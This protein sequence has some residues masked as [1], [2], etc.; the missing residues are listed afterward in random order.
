MRR[1]RHQRLSVLADIPLLDT[2]LLNTLCGSEA[3]GI[4]FQLFIMAGRARALSDP[5]SL[6]VACQ[7]WVLLLH[8]G[9]RRPP[10]S[11][12]SNGSTSGI[13]LSR[14]DWKSFLCARILTCLEAGSYHTALEGP[15][16]VPGSAL[17]PHTQ[18]RVL[19]APASGSDTEMWERLDK[20]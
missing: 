7:G 10:L 9:A 19:V 14:L 8:L 15:S 3:Y 16:C 2:S 13:S 12:R 6:L 18:G 20:V 4:R 17:A 5:L 1:V 11:L